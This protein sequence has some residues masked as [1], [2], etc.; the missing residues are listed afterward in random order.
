MPSPSTIAH[1]SPCPPPAAATDRIA[2]AARQQLLRMQVGVL[3]FF[4]VDALLLTG[5]GAI[6]VVPGSIGWQYGVTGCALG[7]LLYGWFWLRGAR[8]RDLGVV[9]LTQTLI[10]A[11]IMLA[12]LVAA[13]AVGGMI[14][15]SLMALVAL[16]ALQLEGRQIFVLCLSLPVMALS[17]LH[18]N[19]VP[20]HIPTHDTTEAALTAAWLAWLMAK[21]A[22]H[23][24]AGTALRAMVSEANIELNAALATV[25]RFAATDPLTELPNRRSILA[26]LDV[27]LAPERRVAGAIAVAM[28]DV[29]RFKD[30]NDRFGHQVGDEVLRTFA[31]LAVASSR[32]D[33]LVGRYGGEEF[34][35]IFDGVRDRGVATDK[36]ERL[37]A[38]VQAHDWASLA[39]GLRATVSIGVAVVADGEEPAT[40]VRRA[41][42]ALYRAK[43]LGRNRV[44]A[45]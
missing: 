23:N 45:A 27:A 20:A 22:A 4:V 29:D 33:D 19:G 12:T 39:A 18:A 24:L 7:C 8:R 35:A 26:A 14:L 13:P 32:P 25:E 40:A 1:G 31:R 36:A 44:E 30:V 41:D 15:M 37:R 42:H 6:G 43:G 34:L 9:V 21:C 5:Y 16:A 17:L 11:A 28:V 3:G 38:A 2:S 10:A